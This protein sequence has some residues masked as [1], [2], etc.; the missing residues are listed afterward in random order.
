MKKINKFFFIFGKYFYFMH[1]KEMTVQIHIWR[2][3]MK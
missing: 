1:I 3:V 2:R